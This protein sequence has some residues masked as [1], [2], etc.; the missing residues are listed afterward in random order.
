MT[1]SKNL[2]AKGNFATPARGFQIW[3]PPSKIPRMNEI[4]KFRA[5]SRAG[6]GLEEWVIR[7]E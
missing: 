6:F 7:E 1:L 4:T 5:H 2:G 3:V